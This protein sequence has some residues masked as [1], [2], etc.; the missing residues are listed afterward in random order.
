MVASV[1]FTAA[2]VLFTGQVW[3][4]YAYAG[5]RVSW[6]RA[7]LVALIDWELWTLL[8]PAVLVA[9]VC[10]RIAR[11]RVARALAVHL[12]LGA[13]MAVLKLAVEA[14]LVQAVLGPG[15]VPFT[16]L[17]LHITLLTYWAIV[18]AVHYAE[19]LRVA[20]ERD[21]R[22]AR[23]QTELARAQV[24]ALRMQIRPHF[25]FNTLNAIAGLMRE[26][27]EA[28]DTMLAQLSELLRGTLETQ[29]HQEV[30]LA[31]ELRLLR[32]YL[33]IQQTRHG[34]RLQTRIAVPP[35]LER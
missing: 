18:A 30:T 5:R 11:G 27:L 8:A 2:A 13:V 4:D 23:L 14:R 33:A 22:A 19:Q 17:K 10:V 29:G 15:R 26:D 12:P 1:C 16:L 35:E 28:A 21:V 31:E 6:A 20:R 32:I 34:E 9:A 24:D 3:A 25:L 7:F